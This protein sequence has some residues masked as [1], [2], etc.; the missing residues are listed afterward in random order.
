MTKI[1]YLLN[2]IA[3]LVP[4][5]L[6]VYTM[7]GFF[8]ALIAKW[9]G[10]PTPEE[11]GFLSLNP[12]E[13]VNLFGFVFYLTFI[14]LGVILFNRYFSYQLMLAML[15]IAGVQICYFPDINENNFKHYKTGII[16]CALAELIGLSF[17]ILFIKY[18]LKYFPF[19]DF[20]SYVSISLVKI[21]TL[22]VDISTWFAILSLVPLPGFQGFRLLQHI[23][24]YKK[25]Y[26]IEWLEENSL[27]VYMFLFFMPFANEL[28]FST[29]EFFGNILEAFLSLLVI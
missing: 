27:Y 7:R 19:P 12:L 23:I 25:T 11:E 8:T 18:F 14:V 2:F 24:S 21:C 3:A 1:H 9:M 13:H 6:F 5:L 20:P 28:F 26:I 15:I 22:I 17:V 29:V 10:D 16:L 4:A